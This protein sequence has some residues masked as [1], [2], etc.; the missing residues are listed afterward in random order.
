MQYHPQREHTGH[1]RLATVRTRSRTVTGY[2]TL[3]LGEEDFGGFLMPFRQ[4]YLK[5]NRTEFGKVRNLLS[6]HVKDGADASSHVRDLL[7]HLKIGYQVALREAPMGAI[8][9][10]DPRSTETWAYS[11]KDIIDQWLNGIFFHPDADAEQQVEGPD[12][13]LSAFFLVDA[14]FGV[15]RYMVR[16]GE[17]ARI[18]LHEPTI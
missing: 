4:L 2:T 14:V 7:K 15:S 1:K 11:P 18:A 3:N 6:K 10:A 17:L 12:R 13:A 5:K 8:L 16:L 9:E